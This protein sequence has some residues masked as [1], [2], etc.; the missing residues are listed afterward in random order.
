MTNQDGS[1]DERTRILPPRDARD[2]D[3]TILAGTSGQATQ[4]PGQVVGKSGGG[5]RSGSGVAGTSSRE[6]SKQSDTVIVV[7]HKT[8]TPDEGAH[9]SDPVVGWLVVVNGPGRGSFRPVFHGSN[10]IGRGDDQRIPLDFGDQKISRDTH[11]FVIYDEKKRDFFVRDN[12]K[13]NLVRHNGDLVM[14]P[15]QLQDR[16]IIELGDTTLL[17]VA[18]CN[19]EFDWLT[20]YESSHEA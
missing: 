10:S 19:N 7:P 14:M 12:G 2:P 6:E 8:V 3:K 11:A 16:D 9:S 18:L 1:D 5:G 17:F 20:P 15:T 13:S 4:L